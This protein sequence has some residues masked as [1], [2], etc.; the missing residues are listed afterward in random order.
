MVVPFFN[1]QGGRGVPGKPG[2]PGANG[3]DVSMINNVTFL[4]L[5]SHTN[6]MHYFN[7][8]FMSMPIKGLVVY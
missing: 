2:Q 1:V 5:P 8:L 7:T 3:N 4:I 6:N